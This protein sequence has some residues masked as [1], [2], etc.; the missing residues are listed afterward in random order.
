M[1][2]ERRK[3]RAT[4]LRGF[5]TGAL[6][7]VRFLEDTGRI[8]HPGE[9]D[10]CLNLLDD[11]I[12]RCAADGYA[13]DTLTSYRG[14]CRHVLVWLHRSRIPVASANP[15]VLD[16]FIEH[17]CVC[18]GPFESLRA[19]ISGSRYVFPFEAFLRFLTDRGELPDPVPPRGAEPWEAGFRDWL[20]QHRGLGEKTIHRYVRTV[21]TFLA[22]LG[23]DPER[24]DAER[25]RQVLL[26]RFEKAS[27]THARSLATAMRMYLRF[28]AAGGA[29]PPRLVDAVPTAPAWQLARLPRYL[30]AEA[31][32][33]VIACCDAA[34]PV[35]LRDRA[36]LLLLA[37]L[38][39]RAG[40]IVQ[41]RL[42][43]IDW[44]NALIRV[45]GKSRRQ[46]TLPLP[47][48]VGDALLAYVERARP[49]VPHEAVF[50]RSKAPF[51]PFASSNAI[52]DLV[53][54]A[55]KRA[56]M[57]HV[58]PQGAY[59]F[60][61]SAATH[62]VRSGVPLEVVGALLRHRSTDTTTIYAKVSRPMLLEVAQPW[63]GDRP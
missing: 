29:C 51:R 54:Y 17:D 39:L 40:D 62:L 38:A 11:F 5:V 18:P 57:E 4:G 14:A 21:H 53:I 37:R 1:T 42:G 31:I 36:I 59:L 2:G 15:R 27:W 26:T 6:R 25:I 50:L 23:K 32:D 56:G 33:R 13:R 22:G 19:R 7:L 9:L 3:M 58:R 63:I 48:E 20:R 16:R 10:R 35:G 46:V 55:L 12:A 47:Q 61:H 44:R 24:Y 41:L 49:R 8:P 30:P 43:D 52:T 45:C 60:R 34:K 28:L